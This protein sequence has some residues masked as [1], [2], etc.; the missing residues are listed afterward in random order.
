MRRVL[1]G[2]AILAMWGATGIA[3]QDPGTALL[4]K[5]YDFHA[6]VT[7]DIGAALDDG[8][9]LDSVRFDLPVA[10]DDRITRTAGLVTAHVSISN[11]AERRRK[12]G[13][14]IALFDAEG[15]LLGVAS[16]GNLLASI[17]GQRQKSFTLIFE[18][19]YAEA[20]KA[21]AF[22]ISVEPKR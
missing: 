4:S 12:V 9:R 20:H 22:Q 17:H 21:S 7:L 19:V 11:T 8:L 13:L 14:A 18:G 2:A 16:G 6:D 15:R 10:A 3:A 5:R 1:C